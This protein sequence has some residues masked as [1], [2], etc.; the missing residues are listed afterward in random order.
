MPTTYKAIATVTV[1]AGGAANIEFTS[2]PQT[3]TDLAVKTST[4]VDYASDTRLNLRLWFNN[5]TTSWSSKRLAGYDSNQ[6]V[7]SS[8]TASYYDRADYA[9]AGL[10]TAN[11]FSS[12]DIYI[13]NYAGSTNKSISSDT[14][15]ENNS[16]TSW[17]V[18]LAGGLWSNTS[19]ITSLKI[20]AVGYNF[21]QYS[22]ATLYGISK[23]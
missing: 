22:T 11:T 13:P 8:G 14:V 21:V 23:S 1:G 10:A 7:S 17:I 18:N 3:Y 9:T 5:S 12:T 19:A 20:D 16:S 4:R 15:A 2:I 6:T